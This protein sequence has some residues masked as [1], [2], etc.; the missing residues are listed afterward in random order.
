MIFKLAYI[1]LYLNLIFSAY[2]INPENISI[3]GSSS[4]AYNDFRSINAA[5]LAK[6]KG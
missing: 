2:N 1:L 6:H 4:L 3:S 5:A